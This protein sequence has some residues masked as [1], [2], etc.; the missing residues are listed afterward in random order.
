M[1]PLIFHYY[2]KPLYREVGGPEIIAK[3]P[4]IKFADLRIYRIP[5]ND[6]AY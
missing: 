5:R 6:E 3:L 4:N 1:G 2:A